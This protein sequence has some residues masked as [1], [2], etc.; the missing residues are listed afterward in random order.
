MMKFAAFSAALALITFTNAIPTTNN[1][2]LE[3]RR[4]D[5]SG[6]SDVKLVQGM[7]PHCQAECD[8]FKK[9]LKKL[10]PA[11]SAYCSSFIASTTTLVVPTTITEVSTAV[12][13]VPV[14]ATSTETTTGPAPTVTKTVF[15]NCGIP[16]FGNGA[17]TYFF[18]G[19][20]ALGTFETCQARCRQDAGTCLT[21]AF[22]S[23][24]C[25]LYTADVYVLG[26]SYTYLV[27]VS[28]QTTALLL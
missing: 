24:Q 3:A 9:D 6:R 8:V 25:L 26:P 4:K 10:Q 23:G 28:D 18:D 20:G 27:V 2:G 5:K 17:N 21:F 14:T 19:S 11:A 12:V 13:T 15:S 1:V 7:V 16:G 22:G